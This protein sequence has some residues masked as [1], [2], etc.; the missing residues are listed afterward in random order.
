MNAR[1]LGT[2]AV[3]SYGNATEIIKNRQEITVSCAEG[4]EGNIYDGI[5]KWDI[6]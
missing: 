5:L 4:K 3:V 6:K 1:E 2:I